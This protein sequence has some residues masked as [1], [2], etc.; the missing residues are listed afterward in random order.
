M[1]QTVTAAITDIARAQ[2]ANMLAVGRSFS[3]TQ[4]VTGSG[5]H[6]SD[7]SVALTPDPTVLSLPLQS[8]G[9]ALITNKTLITPYCVQY[10]CNLG[11]LDAVGPLSNVGLLATIIYSPIV[12]DTLVGTTFLFAIGNTPLVEK[13]D[14]ETR[15]INI[16]VQF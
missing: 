8:F 7:P 11:N 9:P 2:F 13:T 16:Q 12:G 10:T 15:Q 6:D 14:V 3:V 5:G 4:F 1:S